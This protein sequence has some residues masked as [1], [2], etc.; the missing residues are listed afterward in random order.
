MRI[1]LN[2]ASGYLAAQIA[3]AHA[4]TGLHIY[5]DTLPHSPPL[6]PCILSRKEHH[7]PADR[8]IKLPK[9]RSAE[10]HIK[11]MDVDRLRRFLGAPGTSN[12]AGLRDRAILETLFSTGL[13]VAELVALDRKQLQGAFSKSDFELSVVGKGGQPR[14]VY[15][16][17]RALEWLKKYLQSRTSEDPALFI[18][19]K[20]P[21]KDR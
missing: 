19:F 8:K 14:I 15:F 2:I 13:R 6:V 10:R 11:F 9:D 4:A 12:E 7:Y 1:S 17:S 20:G 3:C 16:S 18:N 5:P 21:K